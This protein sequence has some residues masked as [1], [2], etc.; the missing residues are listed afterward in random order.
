MDKVM[1]ENEEYFIDERNNKW[2]CSD[3]TLSEAIENSITLVNSYNNINSKNLINCKDCRDCEA[4]I[5]CI[6]CDTCKCL[7]TAYECMGCNDSMDIY[8]STYI[9]KA[10]SCFDCVDCHNVSFLVNERGLDNSSGGSENFSKFLEFKLLLS[11][12]KL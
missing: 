6:K 9:S 12:G 10:L 1:F 3:Y 4:C 7:I 2:A 11:E 8:L 5:D